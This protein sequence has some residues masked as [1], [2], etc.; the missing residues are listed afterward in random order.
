MNQDLADQD[1][2]EAPLQRD[3]PLPEQASPRLT[4][5]ELAQRLDQCAVLLDIDGT[6]LDLAPTPREV[7]VPP[8]LSKTL[9]RLLEKT[10]GIDLIVSWISRIATRASVTPEIAFVTG[11]VSVYSSTSGVVLP[12]F[13]P[14]VP[15]LTAQLGV[16]PHMLASA[17]NVSGHL[18]DVSPLSTIGAL[19]LASAPPGEETALFNKLLAWGLSMTVV[20][21]IFC[22]VFFSGG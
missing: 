15:R 16:N 10:S 11:A 14:M 7:W 8:G 22:Y 17:I 19:C 9:N 6:L 5:S 12:A 20:G 3:N 18:V 2:A 4:A 1:L 13:L 21:A